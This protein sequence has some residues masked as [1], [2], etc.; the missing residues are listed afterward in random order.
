MRMTRIIEEI[1]Y[2]VCPIMLLREISSS[3]FS[4]KS[5]RLFSFYLNHEKK[6]YE[7]YHQNTHESIGVADNKKGTRSSLCFDSDCGKNK[8]TSN[9]E[10]PGYNKSTM[11]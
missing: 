11:S 7:H 5:T 9:P 6:E 1:L 8:H 10:D 4:T 3:A 2:E